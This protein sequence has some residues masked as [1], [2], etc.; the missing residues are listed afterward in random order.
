MTP[1]QTV[2]L[3]KKKF[4]RIIIVKKNC[5]L[6]FKFLPPSHQ[7]PELHVNWPDNYIHTYTPH[8]KYLNT[9]T[10]NT[11]CILSTSAHLH[12]QPHYCALSINT[13]TCSCKKI[14]LKLK[15]C[16]RLLHCFI[17]THTH[18]HTHTLCSWYF[19]LCS[20]FT[21]FFFFFPDLLLC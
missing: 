20:T 6:R 18:T 14:K 1:Q 8:Y 21:F 4:W 12:N 5:S 19:V 15:F 17:H 3:W 13:V 10:W 9:N 11:T 7:T 2:N 16:P